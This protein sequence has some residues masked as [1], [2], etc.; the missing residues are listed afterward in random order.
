MNWRRLTGFLMINAIVPTG[1][2]MTTGIVP[3]LAAPDQL[4]PSYNYSPLMFAA[5]MIGHQRAISAR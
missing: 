1:Q 2:R 5:L 3:G 4:K